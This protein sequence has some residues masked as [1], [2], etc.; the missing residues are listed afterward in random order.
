MSF[1]RRTLNWPTILH[2]PYRYQIRLKPLELLDAEL[3]DP[4]EEARAE[5]QWFF[6]RRDAERF[7]LELQRDPFAAQVLR[8][9]AAHDLRH[10]HAWNLNGLDDFELAEALASIV[11]RDKL[12]RL[13]R[14]RDPLPHVP[15]PKRPEPPQP[16]FLTPVPKQSWIGLQVVWDD[17]GAP[18]S[19][20]PLVIET[21]GNRGSGRMCATGSDG[22]ARLETPPTPSEVRC[23]FKD[24]PAADCAVFVGMG[25]KGAKGAPAV[26]SE[27]G[28]RPSPKAIVQIETRKVRTGDTLESIAREAGLTWKELAAFTFG[29]KD[30]EEVNEHLAAEIGC[31][32][33]TD[34][35]ANYVFDDGD[36]PGVILVPRQWKQPGLATALEHVIRVKPIERERL[37][38]QVSLHIDPRDPRAADDVYSLLGEDGSVHQRRT[39]KDD[40]TPV[41]DQITLKY[42]DLQKGRRYSLL[43]DEGKEGKFYLFQ[44]VPLE[45]LLSSGADPGTVTD[46]A[47]A[48]PFPETHDGLEDEAQFWVDRPAGP[49]GLKSADR[50]PETGSDDTSAA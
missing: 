46:E 30:P 25:E 13:V 11:V 32:K 19:G 4:A 15:F 1:P 17:T 38:F 21:S 9:F 36:E 49:G 16:P 47:G 43:I 27:G 2:F 23:S 6:D 45:D 37:T 29:T 8:D 18:V 24:L 14:F 35:G 48:Q 26:P 31:T 10:L 41:D 44:H 12:F 34:D 28:P 40:V 33:K 20:L 42:T 22:L 3:L 7:F 5:E 39:A 50:T